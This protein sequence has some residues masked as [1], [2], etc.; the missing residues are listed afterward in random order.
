[1]VLEPTRQRDLKANMR[2]CEFSRS[3]V[4][5]KFLGHMINLNYLRHG[6]GLGH[7]ASA[8]AG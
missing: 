6:A 7:E 4:Q 3:C 2:E 1:M 5:A 8:S